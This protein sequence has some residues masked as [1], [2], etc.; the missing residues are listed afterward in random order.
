MRIAKSPPPAWW[1][2]R[3]AFDEERSRMLNRETSTAN[4]AVRLQGIR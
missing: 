2:G 4:V 1:R 3:R